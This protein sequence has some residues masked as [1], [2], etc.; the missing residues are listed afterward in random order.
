[1]KSNLSPGKWFLSCGR[2]TA[3]YVSPLDGYDIYIITKFG[4]D[5]TTVSLPDEL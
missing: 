5:I 4:L 3:R 1:M 2:I